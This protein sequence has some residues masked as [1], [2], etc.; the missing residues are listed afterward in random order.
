MKF[1]IWVSFYF[2][3]FL[4]LVVGI[5]LN[6]DKIHQNTKEVSGLNY[7]Q[8]HSDAM[9]ADT[10]FTE[11]IDSLAVVI[12]GLL[13]ELT[14]YVSQVHDRDLKIFNQENEMIKLK[15]EIEKLKKT[16]ESHEAEKIKFNKAQNNQKL[17]DIAKTLGAMKAEILRPV[18]V[19]LPDD[20][21]QIIYD[22]ANSKNKTKIFNALPPK[23]A[24][25]ILTDMAG[26]AKLKNDAE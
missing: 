13:G 19:N 17:Q 6:K 23:R 10:S 4:G 3:S 9:I 26:N 24:G 25:K 21:I 14:E 18:L 15:H 12:A 1:F 2:L 16:N 22:R 8:Y 20:L 7:T 5:Y 11:S